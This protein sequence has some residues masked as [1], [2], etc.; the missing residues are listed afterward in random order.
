MSNNN[1]NDVRKAD[2]PVAILAKLNREYFYNL[3]KIL[4]ENR[5]AYI[6]DTRRATSQSEMKLLLV[7][8]GMNPSQPAPDD[9]VL[10]LAAATVLDDMIN[11]AN[12]TN[13]CF[14]A[15]SKNH[16]IALGV[17]H[18]KSIMQQYEIMS[19]KHGCAH[20]LFPT[21]DK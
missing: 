3:F 5:D 2:G 16:T 8:A 7:A 14:V 19:A 11:L 12:D 1:D 17:K 4:E 20:T 9:Y 21:S 18:M 6:A 13:A 15:G 10:Q